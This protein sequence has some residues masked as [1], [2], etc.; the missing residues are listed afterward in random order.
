[1]MATFKCVKVII[2]VDLIFMSIFI[3]NINALIFSISAFL[4]SLTVE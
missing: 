2:S 4:F 1:M 3:G